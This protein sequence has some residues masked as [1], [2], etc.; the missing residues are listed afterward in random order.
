MLRKMAVDIGSVSVVL[1]LVMLFAS[2]SSI[3]LGRLL[4]EADFGEFSLM[5]MLVLF[6]PFLAIWGQGIATAR[7]FSKNDPA[8]YDWPRAFLKIITL[9]SL[10][11]G[12]GV[13]LAR[14]IYHLPLYQTIALFIAVCFF[15]STLFLANLVR[16]QRRYT[17]AIVM[18]N[19]FRG[20]YFFLLVPLFFFG[21]LSK[22]SA[23]LLYLGL[24]VV[25]GGYNL[26]YTFRS[27]P[28]GAAPVPAEMHK[29]G[30]ILMGIEVSVDMLSSLDT[31][32]IPKLLDYT[33]LGL[34]SATLVPAQLF[35][36]FARAA[37]YVWVPEFGRSN[38]TRFRLLTVSVSGLAVIMA[39]ALAWL[40]KPLLHLLYKGKY[41][42]G[43][44]ILQILAVSGVFRLL[45]SLSSSLIVGRLGQEA[46]LVHLRITIASLVLYSLLLYGLLL[47]Y[48]VIGA[49]WALLIVTIL[50]AILSYW[51]VLRF[52]AQKG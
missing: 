39:A 45:Y 4:S 18:E 29:A 7:Y 42:S 21:H 16:S 37:K 49:A 19:G 43:T 51:V 34:Y 6:I 23:I 52:H 48:G 20:G 11:T 24:V 13:V 17:Q 31:L 38:R 5:R 27:V 35:N 9:S 41:D 44:T 46:L 3:L 47:R 8:V 1:V 32:L 22:M 10:L 28:S 14:M 26:F 15:C 33:A 2:L 36:I 40:A 30:V 12:L 25:W 50:R